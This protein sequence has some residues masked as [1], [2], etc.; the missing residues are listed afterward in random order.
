MLVKGI[1]SLGSLCHCGVSVVGSSPSWGQWTVN[2]DEAG[3]G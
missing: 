2:P 1:G 3:T